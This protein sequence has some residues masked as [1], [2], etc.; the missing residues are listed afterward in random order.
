MMIREMEARAESLEEGR[1]EGRQ[2]GAL[3]E[4][5]RV[6]IDMLKESGMSISFIAKI[7]R[8]SEDEVLGLAREKG[9]TVV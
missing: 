8:L 5:Q 7:S 4:R 1:A 6:A 2:E 9:I 3:E